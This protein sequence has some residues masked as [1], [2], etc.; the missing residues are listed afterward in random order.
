MK[1][2]EGR[3]LLAV[4]AFVVG[5]G[6]LIS[7]FITQS[8]SANLRETMTAQAESIAQAV[9]LEAVDRVLIN[10]LV[11]LQKTL[12]HQLRSH[13]TLAYLFIHKGDEILAH[14]FRE[15][16]P[17]GLFKA[18]SLTGDGHSRLQR[19]VSKQ[20]DLYMDFSWPVFEGKAGVL[21]V[22]LSEK[23]YQKK[24]HRLW[25]QM[26]IFTLA[27]LCLAILGI[28]LFLLRVTHPL[29]DLARATEQIDQGNL[30][31]RVKVK[32]EDQIGRLAGS[33]NR[34]A[35][36]VEEY[37]HQLEMKATEL[38]R[39]NHQAREF[40]QVVQQIGSLRSLNE[41]VS[42][43][44][45]QFRTMLQCPAQMVMLLLS[46]NKESFFLVSGGGVRFIDEGSNV[47]ELKTWLA[48]NRMPGLTE[49]TKGLLSMGIQRGGSCMQ[50]PVQNE[51]ESM[52][53]LLI[54]CQ[55][56]CRCGA[57]D[58]GS[59]AMLLGQ[60]VGVMK[61]A[62]LDEEEARDSR[63]RF[64]SSVEFA[65]MI[66][67]DQKMHGVYRMI[68]DTA[69]TDATVL[70]QG[71]SGTGKEMVARAIHLLSPRREKPF[72]VIDCA[73][74]PETLLESELF[75]HEKGSFT[76][77]TRQK[78][79]RFEQA[80][81][82]TVFLDEIGEISP[83][84][85]IKLLR[86]LQ[87]RRFE[88]LGGERTLTVNV[89][90]LA[91][92]NKDLLQEVKAGR[93]REDLF[94]RLNVIPV[95]LPPLRERRNDVPLL[96]RHFLS[97]FAAE[98]KKSLEGFSPEAMRILLHYEWPGNVR[99]LENCIEHAAVLAKELSIEPGDLPPLILEFGNTGSSKKT[100]PLQTMAQKEKEI[101]WEALER[102][103]WNK[104]EAAKHL[105][106]SRTTLYEKLKRYRVTR[107]TAH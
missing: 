103:N 62:I 99:E 91:A 43:L 53:A 32:G 30:G 93:F 60:S 33:F 3:L 74:Y 24:V 98:Q 101:L 94:Y 47:Q 50:I 70:I 35:A 104:K 42:S 27:I 15:T 82:G 38:E 51:A 64:E 39:S 84:A 13:G 80:D 19:I 56:G 5:S 45:S 8:Y 14:T 97:R 77:A 69:S 96:A 28:R 88:R 95:H 1:S 63:R 87:T 57:K 29:S 17:A 16:V 89:R 92:T 34:M 2:L 12:D 37:T 68:E 86:V 78:S 6:L 90:I 66:S 81:G 26:S 46:T 106:I 107:P 10:D 20:G 67:K 76:G 72:V 40:C 61:R 73:A 25:I 75:G 52:G 71:E 31:A 21:R 85:Q 79:G 9:A 4:S 44:G 100:G 36:R 18:N 105:G 55:E 54:L 102:C 22:G 49:R 65:G 11:S 41:I 48:Q 58:V 7:F 23:P 83:S 59:I